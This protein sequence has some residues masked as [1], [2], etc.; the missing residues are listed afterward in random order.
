MEKLI[1]LVFWDDNAADTYLYGSRMAIHE[2]RMVEF[3]NSRMP[4]GTVIRQWHSQPDY[5]GRRLMMQLPVLEEG[6]SYWI[7]MYA[8]C[9]PEGGVLLR[10]Q[11][12]DRQK[13]LISFRAL[14]EREG[15]VSCPEGT[16]SYELQLVQAGSA[17]V[18][19]HHIEI[20]P[21][22]SGE[23][24]RP[25][26]FGQLWNPDICGSC[27]NILLPDLSGGMFR[28][29]DRKKIWGISNFTIAPTEYVM[30]GTSFSD[31]WL[32]KK[33]WERFSEKRLLACGKGGRDAALNLQYSQNAE[34]L[35]L[36]G[37]GDL[38][39]LELR[40]EQNAAE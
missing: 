15:I 30:T 25:D 33:E 29:P 28:L 6:K 31:E 12:Y 21:M 19:F 4:S 32:R 27:L 7:R 37:A 39:E 1:Y 9:S 18:W 17:S 40:D 10:F 34:V 8:G 11:F 14:D 16:Y 38:Y 3:E 23:T 26:W 2:N 13:H 22:E 35:F 20:Y 24:G 36:N 5:Q